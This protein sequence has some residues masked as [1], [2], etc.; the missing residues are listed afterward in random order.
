MGLVAGAVLSGRYIF[1]LLVFIVNLLALLEF[2]RLFN[3]SSVTPRKKMGTVISCSLFITSGLIYMGVMDWKILLVNIPLTCGLFLLEIFRKSESPFQN[4]AI[5]ILGVIYITIPLALFTSIA[6]MPFQGVSWHPGM[7][8]GYF[9]L[10]WSSDS[11]AYATGK[12]L[13]KHKLFERISPSKT[14]EGS[15]G[16]GVLVCLVAYCISHF[17]TGLQWNQWIHLSIIIIITGTFGDLVK[18]MMK[19][20]LHVKDSG[21]IL[22][23]HGGML[24]RFDSLMGSAPFVFCYVVLFLADIQL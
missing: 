1:V 17:D 11:G 10:L 6:F 18:S 2:Y 15:L 12:L 20:S 21:N 8:L 22:P 14:W 4:I 5:T 7:M 9:F 16:G 23:G 24:D 3:S 19:R 13:G